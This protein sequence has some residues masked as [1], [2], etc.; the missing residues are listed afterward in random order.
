MYNGDTIKCPH[1]NQVSS[2]ASHASIPSMPSHDQHAQNTSR[3]RSTIT[4]MTTVR[5]CY[6]S[7]QHRLATGSSQIHMP[8]MLE[9]LA[10]STQA[11]DPPI[12]AGNRG[13]SVPT[14]LLATPR[15]C[16]SNTLPRHGIA[17]ASSQGEKGRSPSDLAPLRGKGN[18]L[19]PNL[20]VGSPLSG[21]TSSPMP[22]RAS[23]I[24]YRILESCFLSNSGWHNHT[25]RRLVSLLWAIYAYRSLQ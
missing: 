19:P 24:Q 8:T 21:M 4:N 14:G 23:W 9:T 7:S 11:Q 3:I 25:L 1:Y 12:F 10:R 18:K 22:C 15:P 6:P 13:I 2:T 5:R 17:P 16:T 20:T